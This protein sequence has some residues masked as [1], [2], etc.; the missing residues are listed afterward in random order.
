MPILIFILGQKADRNM[1]KQCSGHPRIYSRAWKSLYQYMKCGLLK[2][3]CMVWVLTTALGFGS[4]LNGWS[5]T[6]WL[7]AVHSKGIPL[8]FCGKQCQILGLCHFHPGIQRNTWRRGLLMLM[9]IA[10]TLLARILWI[11]EVLIGGVWWSNMGLPISVG[12]LSF[13]MTIKM[14]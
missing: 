14:N 9:G 12:F 11:L 8:G 13:L 5:Q 3:T 6:W 10:H 4:W 2:I 1:V 7:R